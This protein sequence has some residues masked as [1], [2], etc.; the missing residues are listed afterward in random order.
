M[1][2][3]LHA[4]PWVI[5]HSPFC[6]LWLVETDQPQNCLG[7]LDAVYLGMLELIQVFHSNGAENFCI[8]LLRN[9]F[10]NVFI[11]ERCRQGSRINTIHCEGQNAYTESVREDPNIIYSETLPSCGHI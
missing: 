4:V 8:Y 11:W 6:I 5:I 10:A 7:L 2:L 1:H 9:M 3:H